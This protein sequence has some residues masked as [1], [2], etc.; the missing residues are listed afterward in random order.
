MFDM[1]RRDFIAL[2]GGAAV[3]WPLAARAQQPA[4]PVIGFLSS[5]SPGESASVVAAFREGLKEAGYRE[6]HNVH[7]AFR[8]AEGWERLPAL[9]TELIQIQVA[10]ILA[11]GGSMTGL[12]AK[13]ATSTIPIVNIGAD[14]ERLGLVASLNRPGGNLTGISVLSW[15]LS[16]KRLE[17]LREL[18]P[19]AGVL[20][21]LV[22]P[23]AV[24]TEI[25]TREIEAAARAIGQPLRILK[26]TNDGEIHEVFTNLGAQGIGGLVIGGD[27]FFDS[28]RDV[29]VALAA[30][31]RV[32]TIYPFATTGGLISYGA[33]IPGAYRQAGVY[34]GRI[35]KGEKPA[36][37]PVLQPTHFELVINR[38]T[39][40]ALGLEVPPT[41]LARADE[42][43]E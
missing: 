35:L 28:R 17:I 37:L 1:R 5:R 6:G 13:A 32:P 20:G 21:V 10:V 11:A 27:A 2:L 24:A 42:V 43:I 23:N 15:P 14:P 19:T 16:A 8:W 29:L 9:A 3:A 30:R 31:H 26:V 22:N 38:K 36:D 12:A 34:V 25:E 4:I 33:S 39:A 40:K 18:I 41:L 7:I